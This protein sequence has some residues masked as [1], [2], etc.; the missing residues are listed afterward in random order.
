M[1]CE[2]ELPVTQHMLDEILERLDGHCAS[3]DRLTVQSWHN[4]MPI[5]VSC[6]VLQDA[7]AVLM[8]GPDADTS[9]SA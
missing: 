8:H 9:A 5:E 2:T 7:M 3:E 6:H 1:T 4:Q